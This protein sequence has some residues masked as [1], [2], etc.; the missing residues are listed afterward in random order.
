LCT[1]TINIPVPLEADQDKLISKGKKSTENNP[2][3]Y[4]LPS[5]YFRVPL[6]YRATIPRQDY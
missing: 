5:T 4:L 6:K 3:F 1:A 2:S